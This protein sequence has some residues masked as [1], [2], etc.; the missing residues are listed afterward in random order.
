MRRRTEPLYEAGMAAGRAGWVP[1]SSN[2]QVYIYVYI[3]LCGEGWCSYP[4]RSRLMPERVM[5]TRT[6]SEKSAEVIVVF[7]GGQGRRTERIRK[8]VNWSLKSR[9]P[10]TSRKLL[11][12]LT[13]ARVKPWLGFG[14]R[15]GL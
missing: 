14:A 9:S 11:F 10:Q 4:G 6:Q 7:A 12:P 5:R 8:M 3:A 15:K 2:G 1:Q 13:S